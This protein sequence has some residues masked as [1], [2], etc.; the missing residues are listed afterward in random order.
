MPII[1]KHTPGSFCWVEL[2]TSDQQAAKPFYHGLFG[3]TSVDYPMGPAAFY[4]MFEYQ[5]KNA[6][7]GYTLGPEMAAMP[8]HWVLYIS[9]DDADSSAAKCAELGGQVVKPPFDVGESGR[10]AVVHDPT[11]AVFCIWQ[12]KTSIGIE[13]ANE[14]NTLCWADLS[15]PDPDTAAKFYSGVFGWDVERGPDDSGYLHIKNAGTYIGGMPPAKQFNPQTPPH[16]LIYFSVSDVDASTA[17]AKELGGKVYWGPSDIPMVG[18]ITILADPQGA[19]F[20]LFK[21]AQHS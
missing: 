21:E 18:R 11:G 6:G 17:K 10:M 4:T 16:W 15:S 3:W 8:P 14:P 9:V 2:G 20:S 13:I 12:P 19:V 1:E 7:A 5:G